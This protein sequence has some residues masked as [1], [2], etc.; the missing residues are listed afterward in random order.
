MWAG[1]AHVLGRPV[2][3]QT[4]ETALDDPHLIVRRRGRC[5]DALQSLQ[6]VEP[7]GSGDRRAA[8]IAQI[9]TPRGGSGRSDLAR[10]SPCLLVRHSPR[11]QSCQIFVR[12]SRAHAG[13]DATGSADDR[14]TLIAT[15]TSGLRHHATA[16]RRSGALRHGDP[17][18]GAACGACGHRPAGGCA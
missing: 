6:C 8:R 13:G 3:V 16:A 10:C 11:F 5:R 15:T 12:S 18:A 17:M 2:R 14:R 9:S 7:P 1:K 4:A